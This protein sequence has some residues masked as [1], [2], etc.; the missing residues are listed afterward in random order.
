MHIFIPLL[1]LLATSH[2][3]TYVLPLEAR[4]HDDN[5]TSAGI[6]K[7]CKRIEVLTR[8]ND[9][10]TNQLALDNMPTDG[11]LAQARIDWIK[12]KSAEISTELDTLTA[13]STLIAECDTINAQ[14]DAAKECKQIQKLEKLVTHRCQTGYN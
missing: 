7:V 14:R 1:A 6:D 13:N 8:L 5:S 10:A 9:I 2:A 12:S 11:K 4:Q 3:W